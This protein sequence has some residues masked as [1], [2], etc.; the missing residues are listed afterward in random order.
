MKTK[1]HTKTITHVYISLTSNCQKLEAT[2]KSSTDEQVSNGILLRNTIKRNELSGHE[3]TWE[4]LKY[5]L[6][7]EQSQSEK[8]TYYMI[9]TVWYSG[10]GKTIK[11]NKRPVVTKSLEGGREGRVKGGEHGIFM[12]LKLF[13]W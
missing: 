6:L 13:L 1:A 2:K 3:K 4:K 12:M 9:F 11:E 10:K 7:S 8:S 5:K